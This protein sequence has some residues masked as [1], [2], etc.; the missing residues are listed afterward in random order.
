[1]TSLNWEK[2][3]HVLFT[4]ILKLLILDFFFTFRTLPKFIQNNNK[5]FYYDIKMRKAL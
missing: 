2:F 1:M 5:Q 3:P 4:K